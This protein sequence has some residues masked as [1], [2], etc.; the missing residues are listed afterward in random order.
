M[1]TIGRIN[2]NE[3]IFVAIIEQIRDA[4]TY[5]VLLLLPDGTQQIVTL[6][7][8]GIKAPACKRDNLP[9]DQVDTVQSEPF[10]EEAKYFVE[11]RLLQRGVKVILEGL[12]Q[13]GS[14]NFV[15]TIQ[16]PAGNISELLLSSGMAKCV[17]WS[18][19]MATGGP[20]PLR[21][22]EQ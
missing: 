11:V 19:T 12:S 18:I 17:D 4:S 3:W 14:Q 21:K 13:G 6:F 20:L 22:A 7:L 8:T 9:A 2:A 16:H 5:R 1:T 15:G 10:G